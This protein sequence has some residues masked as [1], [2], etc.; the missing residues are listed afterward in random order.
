[1]CGRFHLLLVVKL[2]HTHTRKESCY[3]RDRLTFIHSTK[4]THSLNCCSGCLSLALAFSISTR[5]TR[6][7]HCR[8][9][10]QTD[11]QIASHF[12]VS[13]FLSS[14]RSFGLRSGSGLS[15]VL[16]S[17]SGRLFARRLP[18]RRA[19]QIPFPLAS[20]SKSRFS[21]GSFILPLAS[22]FF[23]SSVICAVW[24]IHSIQLHFQFQ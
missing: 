10:Q 14:L 17:R 12:L 7:K 18:K 8:L 22:D 19:F 13:F 16:R 2:T 6:K 24:P 21:P 20:Q 15:S 5:E 9:I 11:N 4:R 23:A 1:M 3:I